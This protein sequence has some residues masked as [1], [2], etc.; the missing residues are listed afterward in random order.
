MLVVPTFIR[1]ESRI[2]GIPTDGDSLSTSIR[3]HQLERII[4]IVSQKRILSTLL[5]AGQSLIM[6]SKNVTSCM[7]LFV[8]NPCTISNVSSFLGKWHQSG[9]GLSFLPNKAPF[10]SSSLPC[11]INGSQ[12]LLVPGL[13][14]RVWPQLVLRLRRQPR[15]GS[16]QWGNDLVVLHPQPPVQ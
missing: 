1:E 15:P 6:V 2:L 12:P 4:S 14:V 16:L 10:S 8:F 5:E 11:R 9:V 13:Q 7:A 3:I